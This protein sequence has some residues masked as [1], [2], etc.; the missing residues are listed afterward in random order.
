VHREYRRWW[1]PS[2]GREMEM[3][4]YGHAGVPVLVFPTSMGRFYEWE[5]F[6]MVATLTR[7]LEGG[8]NTLYCLDSVDVEALYN[9]A[10]HPAARIAR[11]EQYEAYVV[12][13]VL[14]MIAAE[15]GSFLIVAG[16]SF[17]AYHAAN[18]TFRHPA[19]VGKLIA[20]G[21]AYDIKPFLNGYYSDAVYFHNPVDYLANLTDEAYLAPLRRAD[22]RLLAGEHDFCR[23]STEHVAGL[24]AAR[25][26]PCRL[27]IWEHGA[28]HD[29]PWWREMLAVHIA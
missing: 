20:M 12:H 11:H 29:W 21:G 9:R 22:L 1:S 6:G 8:W 2:L 24:L 26:V 10:A 19:R 14:P 17:G 18:F 16:A 5:G 13:E 4:V 28:G 15:R 3:L 7:Q 23:H 25:G 27:E